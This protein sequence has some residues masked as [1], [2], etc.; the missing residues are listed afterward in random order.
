MPEFKS[1]HGTLEKLIGEQGD[2]RDP[3]R[4]LYLAPIYY[5][6]RNVFYA[7]ERA[8][9]ESPRCLEDVKIAVAPQE[10]I[11]EVEELQALLVNGLTD[12]TPHR[13]RNFHLQQIDFVTRPNE[14]G[15]YLWIGHLDFLEDTGTLELVGRLRLEDPALVARMKGR[16]VPDETKRIME[17]PTFRSIRVQLL[18]DADLAKHYMDYLNLSPD[19]RPQA[20][21]LWPNIFGRIDTEWAVPV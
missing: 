10:P 13:V 8:M 4:K 14:S 11:K 5:Q 16:D 6:P 17:I 7:T 19:L 2:L 18:P 21:M 3:K 20:S 15:P 1:E 9:G 12:L